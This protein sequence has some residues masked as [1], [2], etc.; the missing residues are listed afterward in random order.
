MKELKLLKFTWFIR[1]LIGVTVTNAGSFTVL[2]L[3]LSTLFNAIT[4]IFRC[5]FSTNFIAGK[6]GPQ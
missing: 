3:Y 6:S 4:F 1:D 2:L 5:Y